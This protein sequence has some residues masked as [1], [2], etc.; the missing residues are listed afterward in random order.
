MS[1]CQLRQFFEV[2]TRLFCLVTL[3]AGAVAASLFLSPKSVAD[4]SL[5]SVV[6]SDSSYVVLARH[7]DASGQSEPDGFNLND[8]S[9]QRNLSDK[10]RND[11]RELG[12]M[13]RAHGINVTKVLASRWCRAHETAELMKLGPVENASVFDDFE[14]NKQHA[15]E[16]LDGERKLIASWR[17]PGVLL[18][19]SHASNIIALTGIHLEEGAMLVVSLKQGRLLAEP[20]SASSANARLSCA[21]CF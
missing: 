6:L 8:C 15:K 4:H 5:T 19:V 17:G 11:A 3:T 14:F 16:L 12:E 9:T 21:G 20:F 1:D 10:G 2:P 7:S 18:V 13:F